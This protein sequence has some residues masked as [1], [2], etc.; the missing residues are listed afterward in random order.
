MNN[1]K[2]KDLKNGIQ[3]PNDDDTAQV[4]GGKNYKV[5]FT[6]VVY[7][8]HCGASHTIKDHY[9]TWSDISGYHMQIYHSW[10]CDSCGHMNIT[11]AYRNI[12]TN[13]SMNILVSTE[14]QN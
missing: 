7:C 5:S 1:D 9:I 6:L 14:K 8:D 3:K 10:T 13:G 11:K 2:K 4:S 12:A